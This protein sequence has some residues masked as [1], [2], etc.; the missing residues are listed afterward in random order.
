MGRAGLRPDGPVWVGQPVGRK[1][2]LGPGVGAGAGK[3]S[4]PFPCLWCC[5][6]AYYLSVQCSF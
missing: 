5:R 1:E 2:K 4:V 6:V 3:A